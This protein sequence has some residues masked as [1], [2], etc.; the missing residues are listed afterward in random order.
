MHVLELR[1]K[2]KAFETGTKV[3]RDL[4]IEIHKGFRDGLAPLER[5]R[6]NSIKAT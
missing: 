6:D 2:G 3:F 5:T 1:V 4:E